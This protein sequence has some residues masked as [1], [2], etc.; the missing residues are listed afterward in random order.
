MPVTSTLPG[1]GFAE[2]LSF[3]DILFGR[4]TTTDLIKFIEF[5]GQSVRSRQGQD[6]R[7]CKEAWPRASG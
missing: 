1:T 2:T 6:V 3:Y 4:L 7:N 5:I